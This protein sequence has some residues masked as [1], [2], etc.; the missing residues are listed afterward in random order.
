MMGAFSFRKNPRD[1]TT[2]F[3]KKSAR[4]FRTALIEPH[5]V[6]EDCR[7]REF[8]L[9]VILVGSI[10]MLLLLDASIIYHVIG[11][12]SQ[13]KDISPITF[14]CIPLFFMGLHALSRRGW[15][16][17]AS[18]LLIATYFAS[19]S[20]AVWRWGANLPAA[21]LAYAMT[22][23]IAG[24]LINTR[25][26]FF[27]TALTTAFITPLWHLQ[28]H[29]ILAVQE[30]KIDGGDGIVFGTLYAVIMIVAWL[31]NREIERSLARAR[32]S[33]RDLQHER[34]FL[35][36]RVK[37]RTEEL[38]KEQFEKIEQVNQ[39]A[40]FGQLASGLFHD[41]LN[42][43]NAL[44][45]KMDLRDSNG[46]GIKKEDA[47]SRE[48]T[49]TATKQIEQFMQA[50]R[51]QLNRQ[52]SA[53]LFSLD[54]SIGQVI[55]LLSYKANREGVHIIFEPADTRVIRHFGNPFK[56]HQ[57]MFNL[58]LN[59]I[60]AHETIP[61]ESGKNRSVVVRTEEK[62][63]NAIITV[64]DRG[65]G[66]AQ[67]VQK[68]IFEPFFSTKAEPKGMG[69]GLASVKKIVEDDFSGTISAESEVGNGTVFTVKFPMKTG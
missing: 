50:I 26:G 31:S 3:L 6:D 63:G 10:G 21:L 24:I 61:R 57:I 18:Y 9:N 12:G 25:F 54:D 5:S 65:C 68:K 59:A 8:I 15:F 28:V 60:E 17:P 4:V 47:A 30:Q 35:E 27:M 41:M 29:G 23:I 46:S 13:Y 51:K 58:I 16:V 45:M 44:S 42:I 53:E 33:E 37:E 32:T 14:S 43:M 62:D 66:M 38:R 56:F 69:I 55:Q 7:R 19:D 40:K 22:I 67:A 52:E 48:T 1:A 34:D 20:Y 49:S 39:F 2:D 36:V 11:S 64:K